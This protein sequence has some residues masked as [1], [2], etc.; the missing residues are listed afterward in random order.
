MSIVLNKAKPQTQEE[1]NAIIDKLR[2]SNTSFELFNEGP[3]PTVCWGE[4]SKESILVPFVLVDMDS[5]K[6]NAGS[7][8]IHPVGGITLS[9]D[10]HSDSSS[11]DGEGTPVYIGLYQDEVKVSVYSDIN[12]Q[13]PSFSVD[14]SE[15]RCEK[16]RID[17]ITRGE[18]SKEIEVTQGDLVVMERSARV[19]GRIDSNAKSTPFVCFDVP[20]DKMVCCLLADSWVEVV[21]A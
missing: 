19:D 17:V 7:V 16:R 6:T 21:E 9:F 2:A 3:L 14:L 18:F 11:E 20:A 15:A 13:D 4:F 5:K 10:G 1:L 12:R 8:H